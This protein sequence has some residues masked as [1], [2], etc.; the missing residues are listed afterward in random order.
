MCIMRNFTKI[1]THLLSRSSLY[2][3]CTCLTWAQCISNPFFQ[4]SNQYF[5]GLSNQTTFSALRPRPVLWR[6]QGLSAETRA[7]TQTYYRCMAP[8]SPIFIRQ[9]G[10]G[11]LVPYG[12]ARKLFRF[13]FCTDVRWRF[14]RK[15]Q[16]SVSEKADGFASPMSIWLNLGGVFLF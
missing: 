16:K 13:N 2:L 4:F 9:G 7:P 6:G 1:C 11:A 10:F 3:Q 8:K 15:L 12:P 5:V 14:Q